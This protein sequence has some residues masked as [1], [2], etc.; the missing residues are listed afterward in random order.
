MNLTGEGASSVLRRGRKIF[1]APLALLLL[2]LSWSIASPLGSGADEDFHATSIW[3]AW[4]QSDTC[5]IDDANI[6]TV[7][8]PGAIS[9]STCYLSWPAT[10]GAGCLSDFIETSEYNDKL[11]TTTRVSLDSTYAPV[12]FKVARSFVGLDV[13]KSIFSIRLFNVVLGSLFLLWALA[14]STPPIKR[15]VALSW[16]LTIIPV[17]IF[18]IA[19]INPSSWLIF[20]IGTYWAFLGTALAPG[21]SRAR[22]SFA[23]IGSLTS[24][25]V[26]LGSR[27]DAIIYLAIASVAILIIRW[28]VI[29]R[30]TS[31]ATIFLLLALSA[32]IGSLGGWIFLNRFPVPDLRW[33]S[34]ILS[35]GLPAPLKTLA[36]MPSFFFGLFGGQGSFSELKTLFNGLP[37]SRTSGFTYGLGWVEFDLPAFIGIAGASSTLVVMFLILRNLSI[38]KALAV[39]LLVVSFASLVLILRARFDF[40]NTGHLQPRYF[41]PLLLTGIG[42]AF[43]DRIRKRPLLSRPQASLLLVVLAFSGSVAWLATATRYAVGPLAALTDFGQPYEWWWHIGPGRLGWFLFTMCVTVLWLYATVWIGGRARRS[44]DISAKTSIEVD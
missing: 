44:P 18:F 31:R 34:D 35:G 10:M 24:A 26:A 22:R 17:G 1:L 38:S 2:G 36:E 28:R 20:S 19:S 40:A 6:L 41:F 39:S 43:I 30:Q 16:G 32:G 15:A 21:I 42:I 25:L 9:K 3:C 11:I 13:E 14:V 37:E 4:G 29:T 23:W 5:Q 8:V 12:Y 7:K 33:G 27:T